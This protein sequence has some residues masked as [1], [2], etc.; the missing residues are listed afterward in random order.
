M[1]NQEENVSYHYKIE[2]DIIQQS[3]KFGIGVTNK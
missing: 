1:E 3:G 2:G